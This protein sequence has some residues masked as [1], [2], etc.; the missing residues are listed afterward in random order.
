[1]AARLS[2]A[3]QVIVFHS[4]AEV[5]DL[6]AQGVA[7]DAE[8]AGGAAEVPAVRLER[9]DDE[10]PFELSSRL[11]QRHAP[12]YELID[13]QKQASVE[14]LFGQELSLAPENR[15][16]TAYHR[17]RG[18]PSAV[19]H[20]FYLF[21]IE[22]VA[23]MDRIPRLDDLGDRE[24]SVHRE[25]REL[26]ENDGR[27]PGPVLAIDGVHVSRRRIRLAD[28]DVD[29]VIGAEREDVILGIDD[30]RRA[31]Q[32]LRRGGEVHRPQGGAAPE[33]H[34]LRLE[35]RELRAHRD[36]VAG[37]DDLGDGGRLLHRED[38]Q[39]AEVAVIAAHHLVTQR[40]DD[41]P[42]GSDDRI[43]GSG[44]E[45]AGAAAADVG[46]VA[47][48]QAGLD[49]AGR[50]E[51][52][53]AAASHRRHEEM[54]VQIEAVELRADDRVGELLLEIADVALAIDVGLA[55]QRHR[56]ADDLGGGEGAF[57]RRF[58]WSL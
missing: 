37:V 24:V 57:G 42:A 36:R 22:P 20:I 35:R 49:G 55:A 26:A 14:S 1:M 3:G 46:D 31:L 21:W 40:M 38:A 27:Q 11:F 32:L 25:D 48:R 6:V 39:T 56:L 12:A 13:D 17:L 18:H 7:M 51:A 4:D 44:R 23:E 9:G 53:R 58:G 45:A 28:V 47:R 19:L 15:K 54:V 30:R 5:G 2:A 50:T 10:L 8:R 29:D 16:L 33:R 52:E 34:R 43:Q 41:R